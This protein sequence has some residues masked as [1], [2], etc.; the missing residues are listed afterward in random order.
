MTID[1]ISTAGDWFKAGTDWT[2][3]LVAW[4]WNAEMRIDEEEIG[5]G[6]ITWLR[7]SV[8]SDGDTAWNIKHPTGSVGLELAIDSTVDIPSTWKAG[9]KVG[10]L[11][12]ITM[13]DG[14]SYQADYSIVM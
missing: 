3:E 10:F 13:P 5:K 4:V 1:I 12:I 2:T 14:N 6:N 7:Q 9:S 8:D 11:C